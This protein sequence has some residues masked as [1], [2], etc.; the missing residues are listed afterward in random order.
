VK[1]FL[2][3]FFVISR[4]IDWSSHELSSMDFA[5]VRIV[6]RM[7]KSNNHL[8]IDE[9]MSHFGLLKPNVIIIIARRTEKLNVIFSCIDN[10]I[11]QSVLMLHH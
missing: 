11:C 1:F 4:P 7:F 8:I 10:N 3:R 9:V 6:M 5:F 2:I